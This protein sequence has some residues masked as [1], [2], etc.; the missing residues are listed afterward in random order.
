MPKNRVLICLVNFLI[1]ALM[2]LTLR[3]VSVNPIAINY[4]FLT[5]AHSHVAM[6]GWAYLMLYTLFS[7]YFVSENK[8]IYTKL[9]WVTQIAVIGMMISFPLQGY[10]AISIGF[11]TLHIF[12]SYYFVY[13]IWKDLH[14][15]NILVKHV[16]KAS[17]IFMVLSTFGVW[18]LGPAV[19]LLGQASAFYQIA[20]QFFLN[21][22]FNGWFLLGVVAIAC[23]QLQIEW[24]EN[25]KAFFKYIILATILTFALPIQWFANHLLLYWINGLGIFLQIV[26][27]YYFIKIIK[28]KFQTF[29]DNSPK[30]VI[31]MYQFS[32]GCF[33]TK[34]A[35]QTLSII[36]QFS[37]ELFEHHN[38]IIGFIHLTMLG[39]ISGFLFAFL[40]QSK[41]IQPSPYISIGLPL[42]LLGFILTETILFIQGAFYYLGIGLLPNYY[43]ILFVVSMLLPV[44]IA[45]ILISYFKQKHYGTETS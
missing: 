28:P 43:L 30:L 20:I 17:L 13:L 26:S 29:K 37:S 45:L 12:C 8:L 34:I 9:F 21:F 14:I 40:I 6:L 19:G 41:T 5:H 44:S 16:V 36:P 1:A 38:F 22:Q 10:A 27:L 25:A 39:V 3:Y 15:Q 2:G 18:C 7:Y 4:R 33:I 35:L 42:F 23:H 32:L 31:R 24:S 11:S